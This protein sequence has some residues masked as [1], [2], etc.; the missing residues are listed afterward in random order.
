MSSI[1]DGWRPTHD[2]ILFYAENKHPFRGIFFSDTIEDV[3]GWSA[4]KFVGSGRDEWPEMIHPDDISELEKS[5]DADGAG[6]IRGPYKTPVYRA[7]FSNGDWH[8]MMAE[9][10]YVS[11]EVQ[12]GLWWVLEPDV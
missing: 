12:A 3:T 7:M 1:P 9:I 11:G 6:A 8:H 2:P 5:V 4:D 10:Q